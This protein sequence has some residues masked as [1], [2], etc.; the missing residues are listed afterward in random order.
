MNAEWNDSRVCWNDTNYGWLGEY[1]GPPVSS[2]SDVF[3]HAQQ[4]E[5]FIHSRDQTQFLKV[6]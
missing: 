2:G 1:L 4:Q 6:I 5:P 3:I